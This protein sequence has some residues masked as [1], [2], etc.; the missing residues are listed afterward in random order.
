[1][2][3]EGFMLP[4]G[5]VADLWFFGTTI[6]TINILTVTFKAAL[7]TD[8]WSVW[9]HLAFWGSVS[10]WFLFILCYGSLW[11]FLADAV[12]VSLSLPFLHPASFFQPFFFLIVRCSTCTKYCSPLR[13][14]GSRA[15]FSRLSASF[16]I[17]LPNSEGFL[18]SFLQQPILISSFFSSSSFL[19]FFFFFFFS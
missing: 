14:S 4:D 3:G 17:T 2:M 19:L 7:I 11:P 6:F 18:L 9:T 12:T 1:M 13:C 10:L 16:S 15:F 8:F 5:T